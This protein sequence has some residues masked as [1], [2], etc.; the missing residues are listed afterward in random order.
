LKPLV[1]IGD[2][3]LDRD[4]RG[5]ARRMAPDAPVPVID[6]PV[7]RV[8]PGGAALAAALA[9]RSGRATILVCALAPDEAGCQLERLLGEAGVELLNLGA[10]GP[11][12]EKVRIFAGRHPV[13]RI[14]RGRQG[15]PSSIGGRL[16]RLIAGAITGAAGLLVSDYGGG[17]AATE[18]LRRLVAGRGRVP[19]VW[20][21]HGRGPA[22]VSG[23]QVA[24]PNEQ[25]A[26][27]FTPEISGSGLGTTTARARALCARW[28][29]RAVVITVGARGVLLV[30]GDGPPL[31]VPTVASEGDPCGAGDQFAVAVA[32][33]LADG[34]LVS[35]A[36]TGAV[37]AATS[38]VAAGGAAAYAAS[39]I[40]QPP[41]PALLAEDVAAATRA[42][43]GTVVATGGCFDLL[44]AGHVSLLQGGRALGDCLIVCLNSDASVQRLKGPGR[45]LVA[46][47]DRAAVLLGLD[48]VDAVAIFNDD[49]PDDVLQRL[50]P[51]VFVKG[52]DY[53]A[54]DLPEAKTLAAWGGQAVVLPYLEG[55]STSRLVQEVV[56]RG[57]P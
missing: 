18:S 33:G 52:G 1:V 10:D 31:V 51:D 17:V 34:A 48:S 29:A 56:A 39:P 43:G 42:R 8:R 12:V 20:D 30:N 19:A 26:T 22:P 28:Q 45:P 15:G 21:P 40:S 55:R 49:R 54:T 3:M 13:A 36:V 9:A 38:F 14:D 25:E 35:E 4:V 50:R 46:Q 53:A 24:T 44:H 37:Q 41:P 47:A 27:L 11:T 23:V 5:R 16:E 7:E 57:T 32:V 6:Q 2:A